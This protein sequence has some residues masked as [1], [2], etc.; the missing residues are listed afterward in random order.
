MYH[1]IC[2]LADVQDFHG[3]VRDVYFATEDFSEAAFT[4]VN[5]GLYMLFV[6]VLAYGSNVASKPEF[7]NCLQICRANLET[8]LLHTPLFLSTKTENVQALY[9]GVS[10]HIPSRRIRLSVW[11]GCRTLINSHYRRYMRSTFVVLQWLGNWSRWLP[12]SAKQEAIIEK[13]ASK[14][15]HQ[16]SRV[17]RLLYSG[18]S[19]PWIRVSVCGLVGHRP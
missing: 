17:P 2:A 15:T 6:E 4:I 11:T 9:L 16:Q 19:T 13:I 3:M 5:A 10:L 14:A 1:V 12:N 8:S 7:E 18:R